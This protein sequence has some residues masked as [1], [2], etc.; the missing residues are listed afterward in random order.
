MNQYPSLY[1]KLFEQERGGQGGRPQAGKHQGTSGG[2]GSDLRRQA[3]G[4][5]GTSNSEGEIRKGVAYLRGA[6]IPVIVYMHTASYAECETIGPV[7][8]DGAIIYPGV[9]MR[10][11]RDALELL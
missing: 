7:S 5:P 4:G 6:S 3:A 11:N 2:L 1:E 10:V 8:V 9:K